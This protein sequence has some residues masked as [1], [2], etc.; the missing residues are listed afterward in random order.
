MRVL[1]VAPRFEPSVGGVE[2]HLRE[3]ARRLPDLGI[4]AEILTTDDTGRLPREEIVHG[5]TVRRVRAWPAGRDWMAAPGLPG[6][7][8][9]ARPDLVHL[10][11]FQ[12]L[13]A[14]AVL[15]ASVASRLPYL[16]TF[17]SGGHRTGLA[18]ALPA[19]QLLGLSPALRRARAL[20]AVSRFEAESV[21][22]RLG[23][24][25]RRIR[26]IA[27]G[28][29]LPDPTPGTTVDPGLLVSVGRLE[30]YKG[31]DRAV[32]AVAALAGGGAE[33]RL[34]ILGA[35]PDEA[36]LRALAAGLGIGDRVEITSIPGAHR[37]A[38]ADTLAAAS[39][40]LV[41]SRFESQGIAA[42]EAASL[43]RPLVVADESALAELVAAGVAVG[44][45]PTDDGHS[46]AAAVRRARE[47]R[48]SDP[49]Q[50]PTWDGCAAALASLY[51][52]IGTSGVGRS[53]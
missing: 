28:A 23:I 50:L 52:E 39:C 25:T 2:T 33:V 30:P 15:A 18:R 31:H 37:Q 9:S 29:D 34:R 24:P 10:H 49:V 43:G 13:V 17:H 27:N 42:W 53:R 35:G 38:Y 21:A 32:A 4:E 46:I 5:I 36:R 11:S 41:L 6:A 20:V 51:R 14:P 3:V 40:V 48:P 26:V 22:R 45:G 47:G 7:M 19:A 16:V 8:R 12:T 1:L 44:V